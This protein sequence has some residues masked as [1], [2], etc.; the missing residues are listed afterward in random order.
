MPKPDLKHT[1][2]GLGSFLEKEATDIKIR[3]LLR[4]WIVITG[5]EF[6]HK[7]ACP[8]LLAGQAKLTTG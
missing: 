2:Q 4:P 7:K 3:D 1:L 8:V 6:R 5:L